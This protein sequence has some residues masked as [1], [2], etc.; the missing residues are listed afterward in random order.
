MNIPDF[1]FR[2]PWFLLDLSNFQLITSP[3][4]PGDIRDT[5]EIVLAETP[6][7]GL[8]YR[9]VLVGG[10]G[11]RKISFTLQLV[12]KNNTV[13]NILLLKQFERLRNRTTGLRSWTSGRFSGMPKVLYYWGTG[14]LPL[15]Y[16][17]SKCDAT[18]RQGWVN[19]FGAPQ[20]SEMDIELIL[21]EEHPLY[22]AEEMFRLISSLAG[23]AMQGYD[24]VENV[25]KTGRP[26]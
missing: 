8:N 2:M 20:V 19:Q 7:P 1:P 3:T 25:I 11:N 15:V 12:R 9:P 13:G 5:K 17:V 4:I 22:R 16:W 21:D 10:G 23:E 24:I 14:S 18:H 6:V 26:Y